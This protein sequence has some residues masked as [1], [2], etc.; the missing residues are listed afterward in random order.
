MRKILPVLL[1]FAVFITGSGI[2]YLQSNKPGSTL[3]ASA[4]SEQIVE[5][6]TRCVTDRWDTYTLNDPI[7]QEC[8]VEDVLRSQIANG[9]VGNMNIAL[10]E[11]VLEHREFWGPCHNIMHNA[12]DHGAETPAQILSLIR[13]VDLPSCQGGLVHGLLDAF[14]KL[15]PS[16]EDFIALGDTCSEYL[17]LSGRSN[18]NEIQRNMSML[19][20]YCTDG[21]GHAAWESTKDLS[22]AVDAC[23][24]LNES[25]G[26]SSC[27]EGILM[28]IFEPANGTATYTVE[29]SF[30]LIPEMCKSWPDT[31]P[32]KDTLVGC[33]SGAAYIYTRPAW[34]VNS[35]IIGQTG[36]SEPEEISANFSTEMQIMLDKAIDL[37]I[38]HHTPACLKSIAHQL[39]TTLFADQSAIKRLCSRLGEFENYCIEDEAQRK[40][41]L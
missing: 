19:Y 37:C 9:N 30:S 13:I 16:L 20:A 35:Y 18:D 8:I 33:N 11:I 36:T 28:Q 17:N 27:A 39:P 29:E 23:N 6:I 31:T 15:S 14:A 2:A 40:T 24:A 38:E 32:T 5:E 26:R 4:S 1:L 21:A 7:I 25:Q 34:H 10:S 41:R 3:S 12:A 22:S